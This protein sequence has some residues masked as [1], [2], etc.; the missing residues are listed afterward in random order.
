MLYNLTDKSEIHFSVK[1][2]Q[3]CPLALHLKILL[4]YLEVPLKCRWGLT[5]GNAEPVAGLRTE[6]N[7]SEFC[8]VFNCWG[9]FV[10][11]RSPSG[12]EHEGSNEQRCVNNEIGSLGKCGSGLSFTWILCLKSQLIYTRSCYSRSSQVISKYKQ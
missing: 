5:Q 3:L 9:F 6:N 4:L 1:G 10:A 7:L 8:Q 11:Q 12:A 2:F